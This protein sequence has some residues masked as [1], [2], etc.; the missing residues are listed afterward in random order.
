MRPPALEQLRGPSLPAEAEGQGQGQNDSGQADQ[1]A[2]TDDI[3]GN[4]ELVKGDQH[5]KEQNGVTRQAAKQPGLV[6]S[7]VAAIYAD[8]AVDEEREV[9]AESDD[10]DRQHD[11]RDEQRNSRQQVGDIGKTQGIAGEDQSG[12][13]HQPIHQ[14]AEHGRSIGRGTSHLQK[15][16]D[17]PALG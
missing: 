17:A 4:T 2:E 14:N 15:G 8:C 1:E 3:A 9:S 7:D 13:D 12:D 6:E 11:A 10:D 5:D 16:V